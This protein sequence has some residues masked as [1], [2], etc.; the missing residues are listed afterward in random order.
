MSKDGKEAGVLGVQFTV[1]EILQKIHKEIKENVQDGSKDSFYKKV[2]LVLGETGRF[3]LAEHILEC[4]ISSESKEEITKKIDLLKR[5]T[6]RKKISDDRKSISPEIVV[7][8]L[9]EIA[10]D[11]RWRKTTLSSAREIM[12]QIPDLHQRAIRAVNIAKFSKDP[13]DSFVALNYISAIKN[14]QVKIWEL[15]ELLKACI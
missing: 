6:E 5:D 1:E 11:Q 10:K 12:P 8:S 14:P 15:I 4:Y 13:L 3:E 2:A 7:D 9:L